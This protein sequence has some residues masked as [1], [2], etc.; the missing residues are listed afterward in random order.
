MESLVDLCNCE[1]PHGCWD[2][3]SCVSKL[4]ICPLGTITFPVWAPIFMVGCVGFMCCETCCK[5]VIDDIS[6]TKTW[7]KNR[8]FQYE[9]ISDDHPQS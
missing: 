2:T 8:Q 9:V 4:W 7:K 5:P 1:N 3:N 6:K